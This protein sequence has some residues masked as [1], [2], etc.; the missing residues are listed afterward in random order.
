MLPSLTL[1]SRMIA[2]WGRAEGRRLWADEAAS[3]HLEYALI[4][5][6]AGVSLV[7]A[8]SFMSGALD[9]F[10]RWLGDVLTNLL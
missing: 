5:A 6:F 8:L 1:F 7:G 3:S 2:A 9:G 10:Y 4:A